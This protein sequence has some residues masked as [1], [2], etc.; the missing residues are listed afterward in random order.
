MVRHGLSSSVANILIWQLDR[1]GTLQ[2]APLAASAASPGPSDPRWAASSP[3]PQA[4]LEAIEMV[5]P[6]VLIGVAGEGGLFT[7][8]IVRAMAGYVAYPI[9]LPRMPRYPRLQPTEGAPPA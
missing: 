8:E 2:H 7:E 1:W 9:I 5:R 6:T 4:L 3:G